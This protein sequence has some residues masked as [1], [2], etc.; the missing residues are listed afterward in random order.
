MDRPINH[1][2]DRRDDD[3][4][5]EFDGEIVHHASAHR[6]SPASTDWSISLNRA[7]HAISPM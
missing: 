6:T 7:E 3:R 4:G 1:Q 5:Q 2:A